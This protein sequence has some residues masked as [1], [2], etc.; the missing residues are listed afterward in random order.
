MPRLILSAAII[1]LNVFALPAYC[2][3]NGVTRGPS[4]AGNPTP[5]QVQLNQQLVAP[6]EPLQIIQQHQGVSNSQFGKLL[7][8]M[9]GLVK[10][11]VKVDTSSGDPRVRVKAPFVNVDVENGQ[12]DV[13]VNAPFVHVTKSGGKAVS[14]DAPFTKIGDQDVASQANSGSRHRKD[15]VR[16][17]APFVDVDTA[18][19]AA[20][21]VNVHAPFAKVNSSPGGGTQVQAPF[22][23]IGGDPSMPPSNQP[24][25]PNNSP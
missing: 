21:N 4:S 16:I 13:R 18:G 10:D 6:Q 23:N 19:G 7:D 3:P 24:G 25:A 15:N 17:K 1:A 5:E 20:S 11:I 2:Q 8:D 12:P 9:K 22:T 14:V